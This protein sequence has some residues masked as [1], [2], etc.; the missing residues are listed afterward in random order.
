MRRLDLGRVDLEPV[1]AAKLL[2]SIAEAFENALT[3]AGS[4]IGVISCGQ[5]YAK[6]DELSL[7]VVDLGIGRRKWL[8]QRGVVDS[9]NCIAR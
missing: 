8:R 3:H 4:G 7:S 5:Y 6:R 2:S 9:A 1:G